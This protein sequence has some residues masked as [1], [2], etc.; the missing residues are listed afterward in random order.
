M[1]ACLK[2]D[3]TCAISTTVSWVGPFDLTRYKKHCITSFLTSHDLSRL[4][5]PLH[6]FIDS[7]II[8]NVD[9][10]QTSGFIVFA[11]MIK[12]SLK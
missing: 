9:L 12:S 4:L 8:N 6:L 1:N 3:Y 11:S 7:H 2:S 5:S 10:D